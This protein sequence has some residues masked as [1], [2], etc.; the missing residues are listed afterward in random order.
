MFPNKN[1]LFYIA[2]FTMVTKAKNLPN[3]LNQAGDAPAADAQSHA[4]PAC[5]FESLFY[6]VPL[7]SNFSCN[8]Y[9]RRHREFLMNQVHCRQGG[10]V[11]K[12]HFVHFQTRNS[13]DFR[14]VS[15]HRS[16]LPKRCAAND[17]DG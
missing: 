6:R 7:A 13:V 10:L 15:K 16:R 5:D 14:W 11:R 1:F 8:I 2:K 17:F 9:R 3:R 4:R 12:A